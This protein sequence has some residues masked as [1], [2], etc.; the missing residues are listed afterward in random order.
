MTLAPEPC[1]PERKRYLM[2]TYGLKPSQYERMRQRG[3]GACW[4]CRRLP[5]PGRR[6]HVD[7]DHKPPNR[8]RGLLCFRC[9]FRLL[10]RGREDAGLHEMAARYLRSKFDGRNC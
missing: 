4:I 5:K 7:H 8:V 10:G 6:L 9:N 1:K 2:K 3:K